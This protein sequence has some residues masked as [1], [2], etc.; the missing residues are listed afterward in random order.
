MSA[1][2]LFGAGVGS[3]DGTDETWLYGG[4]LPGYPVD[5]GLS[6]DLWVG[7]PDGGWVVAGTDA[8]YQS[9]G[10]P[11]LVNVPDA[12]LPGLVAAGWGGPTMWLHEQGGQ[13]HADPLNAGGP[14]GYFAYDPVRGRGV[15]TDFSGQMWEAAPPAFDFQVVGSLALV[16]PLLV[17]DEG[18]GALL[19]IGGVPAVGVT[20]SGAV[21]R[22]DGQAMQPI[23]LADPDDDGDPTAFY[24]RAAGW[25]R[26]THRTRQVDAAPALGGSS[27]W[28]L[29]L[30]DSRPA[31]VC[32]FRFAAA[33][34]PDAQPERVDIQAAASGPGGAALSLWRQ[35]AWRE[36]QRCTASPCALHAL[37]DGPDQVAA[38]LADLRTLG[39]AVGP[40]QDNGAG[41]AAIDVDAL[42]AT[43][44]YRLP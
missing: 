24:L 31:L 43:L 6:Q 34:A 29:V 38:L 44:T 25:D 21:S 23:P 5:A 36:A 16:D 32:H 33:Q 3:P 39:V 28:D 15:L 37:V 17:F 22:W 19:A 9:F 10:Q 11:W 26:T 12:G 14:Q 42:Q 20:P 35:G 1:P 13:L 8:T 18:A 4:A 2:L 7:Y 27:T 30:S 40:T 41:L